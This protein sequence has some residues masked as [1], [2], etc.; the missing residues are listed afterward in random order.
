MDRRARLYQV[1]VGVPKCA[2]VYRIDT[3][4][5]VITP[6]NGAAADSEATRSGKHY[7]FVLKSSERIGGYATGVGDG[8]IHRRTR[9][10]ITQC[11]VAH[12]IHCHAAHPAMLCVRVVRAL[13]VNGGSD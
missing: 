9:D 3:H 6:P 8:W 12:S 10:A 2:I 5:G 13:L 4:A 11:D 7:R 1:F